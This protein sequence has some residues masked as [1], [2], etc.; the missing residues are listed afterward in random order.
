MRPLL[1]WHFFSHSK[2]IER[3]QENGKKKK[4]EHA[5]NGAAMQS[6]VKDSA[7]IKMHVLII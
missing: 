1:L 3:L 6:G 4:R 7:T 2:N 5:K